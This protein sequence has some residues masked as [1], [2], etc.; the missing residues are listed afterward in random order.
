MHVVMACRVP[1][2][3]CYY[4]SNWVQIFPLVRIRK[5]REETFE[6]SQLLCTELCSSGQTLSDESRFVQLFVLADVNDYFGPLNSC[7]LVKSIK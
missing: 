3:F 1:H 7:H 2:L 4:L 5:A 6:T